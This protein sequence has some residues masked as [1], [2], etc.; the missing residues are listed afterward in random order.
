M[1]FYSMLCYTILH[2]IIVYYT[3]QYC[4]VIVPFLHI[5][6][7][8]SQHQFFFYVFV[9][10][11]QN[12]SCDSYISFIIGLNIRYF[13]IIFFYLKF[14]FI[15]QIFRKEKFSFFFFFYWKKHFL[16]LFWTIDI[17]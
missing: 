6:L 2:Y 15:Y 1:L 16:Y 11:S 14:E 7:N 10:L 17:K 9:V 5:T 4:I 3:I 8:F 13:Y 12:F